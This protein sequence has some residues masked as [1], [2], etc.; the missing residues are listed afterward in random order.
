MCMI[1]NDTH[2]IVTLLRTLNQNFKIRRPCDS[3]TTVVRPKFICLWDRVTVSAVPT[4]SASSR[5]TI[6]SMFSSRMIV[7]HSFSKSITRNDVAIVCVNKNFHVFK[8]LLEECCNEKQL[9]FTCCFHD[10]VDLL[11]DL[12]SINNIDS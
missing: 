10:D 5:K 9:R 6:S 12:Y 2:I 7:Y 1:H 3:R 4:W 8:S 11:F